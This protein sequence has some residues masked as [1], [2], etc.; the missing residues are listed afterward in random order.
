MYLKDL[1]LNS[2]CSKKNSTFRLETQLNNFEYVSHDSISF[3]LEFMIAILESLSSF[4]VFLKY[5]LISFSL[6]KLFSADEFY[7]FINEFL[8]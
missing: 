4:I 3:L 6:E 7:N 8:N 2:F 5:V 1:V